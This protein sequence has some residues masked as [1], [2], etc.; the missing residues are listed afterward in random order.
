MLSGLPRFPSEKLQ[1]LFGNTSAAPPPLFLT[2][3]LLFV[4]LVC[5]S[6]CTRRKMPRQSKPSERRGKTPSTVILMAEQEEPK[7]LISDLLITWQL[8]KAA[9][10][11]ESQR[12]CS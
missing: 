5:K 4:D 2:N 6:G 8:Y 3:T 12:N 1:R 10:G 7:L 9:V 11:S